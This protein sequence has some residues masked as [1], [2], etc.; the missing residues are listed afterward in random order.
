MKSRRFWTNKTGDRY[1]RNIGT[2]FLGQKKKRTM[3]LRP[4]GLAPANV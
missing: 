3:K 2:A 4:Q 1:G